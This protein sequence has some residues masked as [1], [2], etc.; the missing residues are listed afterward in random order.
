MYNILKKGSEKSKVK[1]KKDRKIHILHIE[2]N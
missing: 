2:K 1:K